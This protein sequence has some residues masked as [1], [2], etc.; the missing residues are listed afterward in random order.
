M[1]RETVHYLSLRNIEAFANEKRR[2]PPSGQKQDYIIQA[3]NDIGYRINYVSFS[4]S[5]NN[6]VYMPKKK[7]LSNMLTFFL[8]PHIPGKYRESI[9]FRWFAHV[10]ANMHIKEGDIILAYHTNCMRNDILQSVAH[11]KKCTLVYE[12]EEIY[13]YIQEKVNYS[14]V[15]FEK[16]YLRGA[17]KYIY[18]TESLAQEVNV[19]NKPYVIV[20]GYYKYSRCNITGFIDGKIHCVYAG[21]IDMVTGGAFRVVD[22]CK[23]LPKNYVV[24]ICGYGLTNELLKKIDTQ[25]KECDCDIIFEGLITGDN[26]TSF[27]SRCDIGLCVRSMREDYC[28]ASFPSKLLSYLSCGLRVVAC[29]IQVVEKSKTAGY[30]TFYDEDTPEAIAEAIMRVDVNQPYDTKELMEN[31]D[32]AFKQDLKSLLSQ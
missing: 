10:Y 3:L 5:M 24:H 17:D 15:E 2:N 16:N 25:K 29:R 18:C 12:V 7:K 20:E 14:D 4:E 6:R 32:S 1:K 23:Y 27:L 21:I 13:A 8:C 28:M 19:D 9:S 30:L 22:A 26:Y 11:K 31:L